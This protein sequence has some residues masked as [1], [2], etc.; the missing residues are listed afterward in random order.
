MLIQAMEAVGQVKRLVKSG[1]REP[2]TT[3]TVNDLVSG[4]T[5]A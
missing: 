5:V 4:V 3:L 1:H 2:W